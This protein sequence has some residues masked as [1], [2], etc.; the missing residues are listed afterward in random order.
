[1][2]ITLKRALKL[3]KD[4]E[5][6]LSQATIPNEVTISLLVE[7]NL[8]DAQPAIITA[9]NDILKRV[10]QFRMLS[11]T[12][13]RLRYDI[14]SKNVANGVESILA[15]I[16]HIDR[17]INIARKLATAPVTPPSVELQAEIALC[18]KAL[19]VTEASAAR[20]GRPDRTVN[21]Y[22]TSLQVQQQAIETLNVLKRSRE[23]LEDKRA[24][25]NSLTKVSVAEDDAELLRKLGII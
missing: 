4:L 5:T 7:E 13:Q 25:M 19:D 17:S 22:V 1:M 9:R 20:Y 3:R 2:E 14:A 16:G 21:V 23:G 24:S 18:R 11:E 10:A 15:E 12:L 6:F 8:K